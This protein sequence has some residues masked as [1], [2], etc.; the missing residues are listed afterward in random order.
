MKRPGGSE[1]RFS[2]TFL[3]WRCWHHAGPPLEVSMNK[4]LRN[5]CLALALCG[6]SGLA[7]ATP[8]QDHG[9]GHGHG[10]HGYSQHGHGDHGYDDHG[11]DGHGRYDHHDN[12]RHLG[13]RHQERWRH[14]ERGH[15]YDGPV[16]VVRDYRYYD[17]AP[18][19]R[20]YHWVRG[21]AGDYLLVA[22]ATGLILDI[23]TH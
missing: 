2:R 9:R 16:Y 6:A 4:T 5:L 17:L 12:G 21:D 3:R 18:P 19:P 20:G 11:Y 7:L 10:Q 15:R 22:I 14:W 1:L 13:W 8:D 23:V